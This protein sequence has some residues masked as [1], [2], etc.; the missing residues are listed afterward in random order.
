MGCHIHI[1]NPKSSPVFFYFVIGDPFCYFPESL[2]LSGAILQA[3]ML[4]GQL[5]QR[6]DLANLSGDLGNSSASLP[7]TLLGRY[8]PL[9]MTHATTSPLHFTVGAFPHFFYPPYSVGHLK[10]NNM[11]QI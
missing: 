6:K 8:N 4:R 7:A 9:G 3:E 2:S 1:R 11:S 10:A 5:A